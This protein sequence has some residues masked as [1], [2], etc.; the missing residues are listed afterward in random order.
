MFFGSIAETIVCF[1][2][3]ATEAAVLNSSAP[4]VFASGLLLMRAGR[5]TLARILVVLISY[6]AAYAFV[7]SLGPESYF[8]FILLFASAF[9]LAF[10]SLREKWML[11]MAMILPLIAFILL[12]VTHYEPILGMTRAKLGEIQ[13]IVMQIASLGLIWLLM[14]FHFFYFIRDRRRSQEQLISSA[15]MV[16]MGRMAAGIA[17]EVNNPLQLIVSHAARIRQV[18]KIAGPAQDSLNTI[19]D[20]IQAVAMRIGSINKG[21]LALSRDAASD[22]LVEVCVESVVKLSLDYCRAHLESHQVNISIADIPKKWAVF[23]REAQ[24]SEVILN[25]LNNAYYA[26][27]DCAEKWVR[28]ET[29]ADSKWIEIAISDSG[30]GVNPKLLHRIFDPFFTTKPVG[31]GTGLG[32]SVSQ[33]IMAA[34]GG[35]IY[36]DQQPQGAKF[37]IRIP[38]A[39]DLN[40]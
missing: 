8:Q 33:G 16:A 23:G 7:A 4:L 24:L 14:I 12:E 2:T 36:Y 21:L 17:H 34:H 6:F 35:Q 29:T 5:T 30:P 40:S 11:L 22:P 1:A 20:Q 9:S 15:K 27:L 39:P 13:I 26:V 3:G 19:S 18:A 37:V 28:V 38:R 25:I 31:K 32:L 10:F